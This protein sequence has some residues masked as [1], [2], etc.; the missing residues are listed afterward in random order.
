MQSRGLVLSVCS[1]FKLLIWGFE[2]SKF[3]LYRQYN[4]YR[5]VESLRVFE[6]NVLLNF[7]QG[8][9]VLC[10]W[11]DEADSTRAKVDDKFKDFGELV[12]VKIRKQDEHE[13]P[14]LSTDI[15]F[16]KKL[17]VTSDADG[18]IKI[19]DFRK[20]LIREIKFT[21]AINVV[22]FINH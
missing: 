9:Q 21:E 12:K 8:Q 19:W 15:H 13:E 18:L 11:K 17:I 22:C 10:E 6:Q 5:Q 1:E 7:K 20:K 14:V 3:Q 2:N 4:T 16:Q